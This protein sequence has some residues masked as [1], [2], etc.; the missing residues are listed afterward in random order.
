MKAIGVVGAGVIAAAAVVAG[1]LAASVAV[2]IDHINLS[3]TWKSASA[4]IN[5]SAPYYTLTLKPEC[6]PANCY[7]GTLVFHNQDGTTNKPIKVGVAQDSNPTTF[8][9]VFPGGALIDNRKVLKGHVNNDGSLSISRCWTLM[10]EATKSTADTLCDF[11]A[12]AN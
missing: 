1:P 2:P 4:V 7:Q 8:G 12:I 11:P 6:K 3:G 10:T 5:P 9:I